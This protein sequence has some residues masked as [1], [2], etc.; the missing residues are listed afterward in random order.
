M[1]KTPWQE[2]SKGIIKENPVLRL[3]LGTC[4]TLALSTSASNAIGMGLATT[5]VL[6]CSNAVISLLRKVIPDKVRI[7]CYIT[8]IA[9]FVTIVQ[10]LIEAYSPSLKA[11]LGIYLPLIVVNCII[12]G[13]AEMFANKNKVLPSILDGLGMGVGF[14]ATLLVMGIIRELLGAGTVFGFP[15]TEGFIS[16]II[17]FLLPPGGF[18]VFGMLIA[19]ANK[20][21]AGKGEAPAE[22]GCQSCPLCAS[23]SKLAERE[24]ECAKK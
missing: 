18:F 15:I 24:K 2:F 8:L 17:I 4:A 3:V 9:G 23:C 10:M 11:A 21:A 12:L 14:T 1:A 16:P 19:L 20:L 13:R 22:L 6:V 5:F 7:P